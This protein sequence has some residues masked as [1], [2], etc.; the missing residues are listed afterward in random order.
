MIRPSTI[1]I[2]IN[3]SFLSISRAYEINYFKPHGRFDFEKDTSDIGNPVTW[4]RNHFLKRLFKRIFALP[5]GRLKEF[6]HHHLDY[7]L[8]NNTNGSREL[9][10]N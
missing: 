2:I 6:Y 8:V 7:Y 3:V 10:F 4:G 9:F 1:P 5:E